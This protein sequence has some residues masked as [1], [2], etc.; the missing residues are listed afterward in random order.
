MAALLAVLLLSAAPAEAGESQPVV[1]KVLTAKQQAARAARQARM[2]AKLD[3]HLV[4][5]VEGDVNG[6][7]N[8]IVAFNDPTDAVNIVKGYGGKVSRRLG[9]LNALVAQI[10]NGRL[11]GLVSDPRVKSVHHDRPAHG[12]VGRT[13]VTVGA[14]AVQELMGYNGAGVGVAV[15]D[16]GITG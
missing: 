4:D 1:G 5:A 7:S 13:A 12:F 8:V 6:E 10:P 2:R 11:E 9:I 3:V 16:S 15:V 14:H